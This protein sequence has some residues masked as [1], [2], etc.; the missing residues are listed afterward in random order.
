MTKDVAVEPEFARPVR[1]DKLD[2]DEMTVTIEADSVERAALAR[3]F[4]LD[5]ID[6]FSATVTVSREDAG[7]FRVRGSL[8]ADVLQTCVVSLEPVATHVHEP[9]TALLKIDSGETRPGEVDVSLDEDEAD[10]LLIGDEID[11]GELAA[12]QL[13]LVLDPYPRHPDATLAAY[14][15]PI[16]STLES[17]ASGGGPFAVLAALR[18]KPN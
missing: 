18:G 13:A 8:D 9:F 2:G 1:V 3:R 4:E 11:V 15:Q 10:D 12:Q 5:G 14:G 16:D 7:T 17:D 6:A